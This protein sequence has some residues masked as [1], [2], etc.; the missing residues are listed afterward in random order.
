MRSGCKAEVDLRCSFKRRV[1]E[2]DGGYVFLL[3][4]V[5]IYVFAGIKC[6]IYIQQGRS[7]PN[8]HD[9]HIR[10]NNIKN[11][12]TGYIKVVFPFFISFFLSI[13]EGT[14]QPESTTA[15]TAACSISQ[16]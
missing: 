11:K 8:V 7:L 12:I 4:D 1:R 14:A 10:N 2:G 15:L 9:L 16:L 5:L 3:L 6:T 13:Q